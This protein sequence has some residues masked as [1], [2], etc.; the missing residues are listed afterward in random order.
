MLAPLMV[1]QPAEM[2]HTKSNLSVGLIEY[3]L[4]NNINKI[5]PPCS[6]TNVRIIPDVA[7]PDLAQYW[8]AYVL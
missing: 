6:G 3:I 8:R 7:N 2:S 5:H 1:N 4:H